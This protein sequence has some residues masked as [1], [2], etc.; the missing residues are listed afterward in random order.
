[1][2]AAIQHKE[3]HPQPTGYAFDADGNQVATVDFVYPGDAPEDGEPTHAAEVQEAL[4]EFLAG[5]AKLRVSPAGRRILLLAYLAGKTDFK[6]DAEL[7]RHFRI[8]ATRFSHLKREFSS[9]VASLS[10]LGNRQRKRKKRN[11]AA[12]IE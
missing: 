12:L 8:S 10:R 2:S 9:T 7:A 1:V 6:T 3:T 11:V 4:A 5:F